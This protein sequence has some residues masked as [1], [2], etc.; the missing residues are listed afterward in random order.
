MNY[1]NNSN[2]DFSAFCDSQ[3]QKTGHQGVN[4]DGELDTSTVSELGRSLIRKRKLPAQLVELFKPPSAS[5]VRIRKKQSTSKSSELKSLYDKR[6][7]EITNC[8]TLKPAAAVQ[9]VMSRALAQGKYYLYNFNVFLAIFYWLNLFLDDCTNL[10]DIIKNVVRKMN[11][12][13]VQVIQVLSKHT[14]V[15]T[16]HPISTTYHQAGGP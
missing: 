8:T 1:A 3:S 15:Q 11:Q 2:L 9:R 5:Q 4:F 10:D 13:L 12:C 7:A 14:A 6:L 16:Y